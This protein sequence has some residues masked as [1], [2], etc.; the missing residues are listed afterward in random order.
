MLDSREM[1]FP[2]LCL[3]ISICGGYPYLTSETDE[4]INQQE[5]LGVIDLKPVN[6]F[7]TNIAITQ[8]APAP[9]PPTKH[10]EKKSVCL[11]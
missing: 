7:M 8:L 2:Q 1:K 5:E 10:Q 9:Q 4:N 3:F 11:I 6:Q